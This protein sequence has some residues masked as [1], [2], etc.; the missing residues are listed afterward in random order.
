M[1]KR[2]ILYTAFHMYYKRAGMRNERFVIQNKHAIL[3]SINLNIPSKPKRAV[4]VERKFSMDLWAASSL[5]EYN[6]K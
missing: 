6:E 4:I 2:Y 1:Y 3:C 5:H